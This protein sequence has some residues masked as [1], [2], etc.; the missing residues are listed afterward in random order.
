[1][2]CLIKLILRKIPWKYRREVH[3]IIKYLWIFRRTTVPQKKFIIYGCGRSGSTLLTSLLNSHPDIYVDGEIFHENLVTQVRFPFMYINNLSKRATLRN[4]NVYG[5]GI[6]SRHMEDQKFINHRKF[7]HKLYNRGWYIIHLRRRNV[8]KKVL[9]RELA[10]EDG[11][12]EI[13][14]DINT[15]ERNYKL[16]INNVY[17]NILLQNKLYELE[18]EILNGIEHF[19]I[20]YEDH[21]EYKDNWVKK[22]NELAQYFDLEVFSPITNM[23]KKSKGTETRDIT[24]YDDLL[25][26]LLKKGIDV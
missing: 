6:M 7:I 14:N 20:Y 10:M 26:Y 23:R 4:K 24:N 5:C 15:N 18:D 21:L 3:L 22:L 8:F 9:S 16:N 25:Q 17:R 11:V 19:K 2:I 12:W 13:K 1:M